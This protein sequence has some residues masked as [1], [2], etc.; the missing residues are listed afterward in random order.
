MDERGVRQGRR[1][2]RA[3]AV[4][5]AAAIIGQPI[6]VE[7]LLGIGAVGAGTAGGEAAEEVLAHFF[8]VRADLVH[9]APSI[10]FTNVT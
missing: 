3:G 6:G 4:V 2:I 7:L 8:D 10:S 1:N 5:V 9:G